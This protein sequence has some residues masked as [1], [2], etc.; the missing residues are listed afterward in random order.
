MKSQLISINIAI[1]SLFSNF[2]VAGE[3][4]IPNKFT[5]G[6][7]A[8]AAEVN[9]NFTAVEEA[10]DGNASDIATL[11]ESLALLTERIT[12]L[13]NENLE[14]NESV[15]ALQQDNSLMQN[16]ITEV[17]PYIEGTLDEQ[18]HSTIV[19]SD[20]NVHINN[21]QDSVNQINGRGNLIVGYNQRIGSSRAFCTTMD[22]LESAYT[23]QNDCEANAGIW[24]T[25]AQ[26]LGSHNLL[27]GDG[28][29]Y[30]QFGALISGFN[31]VAAGAYT[32][33]SG[34]ER[35]LANGVYSSISGGLVN[36]TNGEH[37][38]VSGGQANKATGGQSSISGGFGNSSTGD[39][40]SIAGGQS[41][42][43]S[44]F[45]SSVTAGRFNIA[46]GTESSVT[47]GRSNTAS[48]PH[49]S[50]SGGFRRASE[51]SDNWRGGSLLEQN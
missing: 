2:L 21:G 17:L 43:A 20:V 11:V 46:S 14:L 39:T 13:E 7:K 27:I 25:A 6:T 3:L 30:T 4:D 48:G 28:H 9:D 42:V 8:V 29:S 36:I 26:K 32:T 50:V 12:S 33:I 18:G 15:T 37:S 22:N 19:F 24:G 35:N 16:F 40:S 5:A 44:G 23:T 49:S 38:S 45:L 51:A 47:G 31:N 41:N 10:V 34:G 1:A